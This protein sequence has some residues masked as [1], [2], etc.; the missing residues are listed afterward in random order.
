MNANIGPATLAALAAVSPATQAVIDAERAVV[1]AEGRIRRTR[2]AASK[3]AAFDEL[4]A[5]ETRLLVA[6]EGQRAE[7]RAELHALPFEMLER[8]LTSAQN[9]AYEAS[10]G[11]YSMASI[12]RAAAD[13]EDTR[14]VYTERTGIVL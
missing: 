9:Y 3:S 7:Y 10:M 6:R 4:F 1:A 2:S 8:R 11:D 13:L 5:A 14:Q 12:N